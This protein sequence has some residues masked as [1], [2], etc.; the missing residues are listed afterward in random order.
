MY[1]PTLDAV[2]EAFIAWRESRSSQREPIPQILWERVFQIHQDY[3]QAE[4]CHRLRLN[5]GQCKKK[6]AEI[7]S[8]SEQGGFV[9]AQSPEAH[10]EAVTT[11][12]LSSASR[13]LSVSVG[14]NEIG[15][16]LPHFGALL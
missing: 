4:I 13:T 9:I 14:I 10:K 1:T 15:H 2:E 12:S 5:G 8:T 7:L 3:S 16:V 11:V 6:M